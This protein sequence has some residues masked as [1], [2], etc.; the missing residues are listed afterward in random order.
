MQRERGVGPTKSSSSIHQG[1]ASQQYDA[2]NQKQARRQ[3][4]NIMNKYKKINL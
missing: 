1:K 2:K 3:L 4:N